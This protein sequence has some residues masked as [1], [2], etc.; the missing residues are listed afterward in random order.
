MKMFY[1]VSSNNCILCVNFEEGEKPE[2]P[3]KNP[4]STGEIN[5]GNSTH[6]KYHTRLGFS[7]ER[8][9]ALTVCATRAYKKQCHKL[10]TA[11]KGTLCIK[12]IH[13]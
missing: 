11:M 7:G 8:H 12:L 6:M 10:Q 13:T 9:N 4:R 5:Y 2:Y 1:S 3:D